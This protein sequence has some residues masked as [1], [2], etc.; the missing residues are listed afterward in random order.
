[1]KKLIIGLLL[2]CSLLFS[3]CACDG[4]MTQN[5]Y[6]SNINWHCTEEEFRDTYFNLYY[7]K[8]EALNDMY[9]IECEVTYEWKNKNEIAFY[10]YNSS[11][12]MHAELSNSMRNPTRGYCDTYLYVY[13]DDAK[14][15]DYD[16]QGIYVA[17]M[18]DFINYVAYD[19][20]TSEN[21]FET[22]YK[23]SMESNRTF[24][25]DCFCEPVIP[26]FTYEIHRQNT[27]GRYFYEMSMT[28]ETDILCNR[29]EFRGALKPLY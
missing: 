29:Y 4:Q 6:F 14:L 24:A 16:A 13:G 7:E 8:I 15:N 23:E 11:F 12:T 19:T 9:Q 1:M 22:L 10:I 21:R 2:I 20:I 17:Y 18:N 3:L 27:Y 26:Y 28:N 5:E 25:V